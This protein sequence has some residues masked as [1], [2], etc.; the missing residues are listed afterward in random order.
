M[1]A[2]AVY[3]IVSPIFAGQF[4][5]IFARQHMQTVAYNPCSAIRIRHHNICS[6]TAQTIEHQVKRRYVSLDIVRTRNHNI[7][8]NLA[9][10]LMMNMIVENVER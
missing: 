2:F 6:G 4:A 1:G 5:Y 9:N 3:L 7:F 10:M 8:L